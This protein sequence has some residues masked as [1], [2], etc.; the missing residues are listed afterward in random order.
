MS[1]VSVAEPHPQTI[2]EAQNS[3]KAALLSLATTASESATPFLCPSGYDLVVELREEGQPIR[4]NASSENW[5][6]EKGEVFI[7]FEK[8]RQPHAPM[9]QVVEA[10]P[11][12]NGNNES[13][14]PL[15]QLA[16]ALHETERTRDFV[17]LKW[18]RDDVLPTRGFPWA[19]DPT[20]RQTVMRDAIEAGYVLTSRVH[21]PHA[22]QYPTTTIRAN[23]VK[24]A[25]NSS[26]PPTRY[27]PVPVRGEPV[28][29]TL[30]R[31]RGPR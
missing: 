5:S 22:P 4:R 17:S 21:N 24:L 27:N 18:F 28:S 25:G 1:I 13:E 26:A 10:K 23:R 6:P 12:V 16:N 29:T 15:K 9:P 20:E 30:L 11:A 31:D 3:I 2:A 7:Y 14:S 19:Q 8:Q